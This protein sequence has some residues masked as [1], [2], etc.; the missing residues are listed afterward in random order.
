MVSNRSRGE[1]YGYF[2]KLSHLGGHLCRWSASL[3]GGRW[4]L[5][6]ARKRLRQFKLE[7]KNGIASGDY[8]MVSA[9]AGVEVVMMV[10]LW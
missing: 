2:Q 6:G 9:G 7:E 8:G 1:G 5:K 10:V 4:P 3:E